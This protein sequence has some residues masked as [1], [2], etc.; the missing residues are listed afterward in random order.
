MHGNIMEH[1]QI[2]LTCTLDRIL[3]QKVFRN[4]P[5]IILIITQNSSNAEIS[6]RQRFYS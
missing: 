6:E 1:Q 2:P 4:R 3:D 5:T